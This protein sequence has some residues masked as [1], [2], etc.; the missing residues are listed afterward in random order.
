M[1]VGVAY[2]GARRARSFFARLVRGVRRR[3]RFFKRILAWYW[4][5]ILRGH[6]EK[7]F[8][9][10]TVL[11]L[12]LQYFPLLLIA[13]LAL[14]RWYLGLAVL[15]SFFFI[16][17]LLGPS[18]FSLRGCSARISFRIRGK[19]AGFPIASS[20]KKALPEMDVDER[21]TK[22]TEAM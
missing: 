5:E 1:P 9:A 17:W 6:G 20:Q 13:V 19:S 11:R 10:E 8:P 4:R 2:A 22:P 3:N 15:F 16:P 21:P 14:V 18:F 7:E 12:S